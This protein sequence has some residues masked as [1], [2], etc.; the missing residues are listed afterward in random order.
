MVS[1]AEKREVKHHAVHRHISFCAPC[2]LKRLLT[3][4]L[5]LAAFF[6]ESAKNHLTPQDFLGKPKCKSRRDCNRIPIA[7][8]V[9]CHSESSYKSNLAYHIFA[10]RRIL[11][12]INYS[13]RTPR[14]FSLI[15][16]RD[17][18]QLHWSG[19][20]SK[21]HGIFFNSHQTRLA[22]LPSVP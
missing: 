18:S 4:R 16:S 2:R 14:L 3:I 6:D 7:R 11:C 8:R 13:D 19:K 9:A 12:C 21:Y 5:S 20:N 17:F 15:S 1:G 10:E 22:I